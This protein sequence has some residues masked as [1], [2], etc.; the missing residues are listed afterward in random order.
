MFRHIYRVGKTKQNKKLK[1][2]AEGKIKNKKRIGGEWVKPPGYADNSQGVCTRL[3]M[4][5]TIITIFLIHFL[6]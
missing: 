3:Y 2:K 5:V 6:R 4:L 1:I